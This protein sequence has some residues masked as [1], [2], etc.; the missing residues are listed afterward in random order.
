VGVLGPLLVMGLDAD[1]GRT[2]LDIPDEEIDTFISCFMYAMI[3]FTALR[4]WV[5]PP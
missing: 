2:G 5:C 3:F 1:V 4:V